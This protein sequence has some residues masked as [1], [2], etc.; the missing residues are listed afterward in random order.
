MG[1]KGKGKGERE[2]IMEMC[3]KELVEGSRE[4]A[5]GGK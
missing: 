4:Q 2:R 1:V 5:V 3:R